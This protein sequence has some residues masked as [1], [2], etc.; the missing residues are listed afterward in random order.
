MVTIHGDNKFEFIGSVMPECIIASL[1]VGGS[2]HAPLSDKLTRIFERHID[3][4]VKGLRNI[5]GLKRAF[6]VMK[7]KWRG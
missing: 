4:V 1:I 2:E 6:W 7:S 5:S 3:V